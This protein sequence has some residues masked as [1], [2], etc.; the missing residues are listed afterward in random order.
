MN[1]VIGF[2]NAIFWTDDTEILYCEFS[3]ADPN[4]K[5]EAKNVKSYMK[6]IITLCDGKSMPFLIDLRDTCGSFTIEAAK[7]LAKNPELVELRV[8]ESYLINSMGIKLL[9]GLYKR[10]YDR[11]TPFQIFKDL[12]SAIDFCLEAK[13]NNDSNSNILRLAK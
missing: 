4:S 7:L 2:N 8:S 5:L 3:N 1:K 9:I 10:L 6:A 12:N 11:I 13:Y